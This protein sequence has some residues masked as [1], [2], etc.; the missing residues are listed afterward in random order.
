MIEVELINKISKDFGLDDNKF[1]TLQK[2]F[3]DNK[4]LKL[5]VYKEYLIYNEQRIYMSCENIRCY[6]MNDGLFD[7]VYLLFERKNDKLFI[8]EIN[9]FELKNK[10]MIMSKD[11]K[12]LSRVIVDK[13]IELNMWISFC[14]SCTGGLACATLLNASRASEVLKESYVTYAASAKESILKVKKDTIDR[15]SV[16]S[17]EVAQ[18]MVQGLYNITLADVCVSITGLASGGDNIVG[19]GTC[20]IGI[21]YKGV[22]HLYHKVFYSTRNE[23][24]KLQ[25]QSM[26]YEVW[27]LLCNE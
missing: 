22:I 26:L 24:R 3:C 16:Y 15:F 13:L 18:E 8:D 2:I 1:E 9:K 21:L 17:K 12:T 27:L 6:H 5:V 11:G 23:I 4:F 7:K 20:D 25:V 14:E 10:Q 19:D